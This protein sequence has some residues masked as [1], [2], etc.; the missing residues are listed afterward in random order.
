LW[1]AGCSFGRSTWKWSTKE[2]DVGDQPDPILNENARMKRIIEDIGRAANEC[3][4][5]MKNSGWPVTKRAEA[6]MTKGWGPWKR[7]WYSIY[8]AH[9]DS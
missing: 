4:K 3:R 5:N 6:M 9:Q 7:D 1:Y 2:R 8:S